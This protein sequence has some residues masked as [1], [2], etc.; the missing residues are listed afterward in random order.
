MFPSPIENEYS[1]MNLDGKGKSPYQDNIDNAIS[2]TPLYLYD[3]NFDYYNIDSPICSIN[4]QIN[5]FDLSKLL[6]KKQDEIEDKKDKDKMNLNDKKVEKKENEP[7]N[8]SKEMAVIIDNKSKLDL[9]KLTYL[10]SYGCL[11]S[12]SNIDHKLKNPKNNVK[13]F[14][15]TKTDKKR[16]PLDFYNN[17]KN[18]PIKKRVTQNNINS[19]NI[20]ALINNQLDEFNNNKISKNNIENIFLQKKRKIENNIIIE[21]KKINYENITNYANNI[22]MKKNSSLKEKNKHL[23]LKIKIP[24]NIITHNSY[25][26]QNNMQLPTRNAYNSRYKYQNKI[27]EKNINENENNIN[28]LLNNQNK[29]FNDKRIIQKM[30]DEFDFNSS[31]I[32]NSSTENRKEKR[33]QSKYI[34]QIYESHAPPIN[35]NGIEYTTLLVPK[36][37]AEK[38]KSIIV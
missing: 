11:N 14:G 37:F 31:K 21:K 5:K 34:P 2:I 18:G 4:E 12:T 7:V 16:D 1:K 6:D 26:Y 28:N 10:S 20:N 9:G 25:P 23:N 3:N 13:I 15:L 35:I 30:P 17:D 38:I 27:N 22:E 29:I 33:I 32:K 36:I 24:K 19:N 8:K